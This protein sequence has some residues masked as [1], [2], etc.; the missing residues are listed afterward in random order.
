MLA[1]QQ[2]ASEAHQNAAL[3][4]G[5]ASW[6]AADVSDAT[7]SGAPHRQPRV[8]SA[9]LPSLTETLVRNPHAMGVG[10]SAGQQPNHL[11]ID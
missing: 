8:L 9:R 3:K 4:A 10:A 5:L 2:L 6:I 1:R 11:D 7:P